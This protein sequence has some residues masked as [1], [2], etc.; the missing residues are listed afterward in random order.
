[1][2]HV[3][4]ILHYG[5]HFMKYMFLTYTY[6]TLLVL[7][8]LH[9]CAHAT[10]L[11]YGENVQCHRECIVYDYNVKYTFTLETTFWKMLCLDAR[12][13]LRDPPRQNG[14]VLENTGNVGHFL[15]V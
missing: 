12:G 4:A 6:Y 14:G 1:M 9:M 8:K 2:H 11:L 15:C 13:W 3:C 7:F 5:T 10:T